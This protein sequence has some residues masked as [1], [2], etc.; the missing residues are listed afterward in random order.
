[1]TV[2]ASTFPGDIQ[3]PH[4]QRSTAAS[5]VVGSIEEAAMTG[6]SQHGRGWGTALVEAPHDLQLDAALVSITGPRP[7]NQDAA[8]AG[9]SLLAV[10]D[11]VGGNVGGAVASSLAVDV[12]RGVVEQPGAKPPSDRLLD[13]VAAANAQLD[14]AVAANPGLAG[15]ATTLTAVALSGDRL[16]IAHVGDSRAYLLREGELRQLTTDQTVVQS[17]V[18]G[19]VITIDQARTHPLRSVLL[20]ALRGADD[21]LEHLVTTVDH[22]RSADRLLVCSDGLS[23][24]VEPD[25]IRRILA[26][27]ERPSAAVNRLVRAALAAD[28]HDNVTVVVGDVVPTATAQPDVRDSTPAGG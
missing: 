21:D 28:T 24:V 27:E 26:E 6:T 22:A 20:G 11:G 14:H 8:F 16:T 23:G 13:A 19:G 17:L 3:V 7:D 9:P 4:I 1:M 18:D 12:V 5:I 10:A 25:L 2:S 15:M